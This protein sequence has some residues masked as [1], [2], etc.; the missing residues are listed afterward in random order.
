LPN[1]LANIDCLKTYLVS[2]ERSFQGLSGVIK[3]IEIIKELVEIGPNEVYNKE[4]VLEQ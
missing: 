1:S 2:I 4:I 3:T